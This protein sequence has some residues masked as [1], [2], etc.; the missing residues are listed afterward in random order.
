MTQNLRIKS[1]EFKPAKDLVLVKPIELDTGEVTTDT[2][3]V[4]DLEQNQSIIDRP[5]TGTVIASACEDYTEGTEVMW[6]ETAGQDIEFSDG[7]FMVL[8]EDTIIGS[9]K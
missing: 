5:T 3:L 1:T 6:L 2:G 8:K 4:V 9:T 7:V